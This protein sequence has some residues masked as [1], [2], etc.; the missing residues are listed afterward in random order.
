MDWLRRVPNCHGA[1]ENFLRLLRRSAVEH[2]WVLRRRETG[3]IVVVI[4]R[5]LLLVLAMASQRRRAIV[6]GPHTQT[7]LPLIP[8]ASHS[9]YQN[10]L[11]CVAQ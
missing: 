8:I 6:G 4:H 10:S 7:K 5:L 2:S 1:E 11:P 3:G 9:G